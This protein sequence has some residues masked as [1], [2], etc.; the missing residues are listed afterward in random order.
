M[1]FGPG[2]G[3]AVFNVEHKIK[4][5]SP[6]FDRDCSG[7]TGE[8]GEPACRD[9]GNKEGEKSEPGADILHLI[10]SCT[11]QCLV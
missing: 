3:S 11:V 6:V 7:L 8:A 4:S 1:S 10:L 2:S 5:T 9:G